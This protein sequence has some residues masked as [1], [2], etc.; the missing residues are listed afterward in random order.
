MELIEKADSRKLYSHVEFL[1]G[2]YPPRNYRNTESLDRAAD[3]IAAEFKKYG[4]RTSE[5]SYR[6]DHSTYRNIIGSA[7]PVNGPLLVVGAHYDVAGEQPG[8]D[9]NASAVAGLLETARLLAYQELK[10]RVD[11]VAYPLEEPPYFGSSKMGSAVHAESLY[12]A[13]EEVI[14]MIC[15][16]M[17]GYFSDTPGSQTHPHDMKAEHYPDTGN[18]VGVTGIEKYDWWIQKFASLM[19]RYTSIPVENACFASPFSVVSLSDQ[20]NYW[21]YNYP[22]IMITDTS[23]FRNPYYH[24]PGDTIDTL[25]F[26]RMAE[27]VDGTAGALL[28]L[29]RL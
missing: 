26:E 27:V 1:T 3:Y 7:G 12:N 2:L 13:G 5:Q 21:K 11:F 28:E 14:I 15:F 6:A 25:D 10:I 8:A 16:E 29:A 24:T 4:C 20:R 18:Y 9:D 23:Y 17:I 19:S 22:A